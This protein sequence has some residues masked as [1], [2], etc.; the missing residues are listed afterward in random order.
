MNIR[1]KSGIFYYKHFLHI[2]LYLILNEMF[3]FSY[4]LSQEIGLKEILHKAISINP[5]IHYLENILKSK[6]GTIKQADVSPNPS[7]DINAGNKE[8]TI[9]FSQN[10]E[11]PGKR[12]ARK[13][14]ANE[15]KDIAKYQIMQTKIEIEKEISTIYYDVLWVKGNVNLYRENLDIT[16]KYMKSTKYQYDKGFNNK[17]DLLKSK[18]EL[19]RAQRLL[20]ESEQEYKSYISRLRAMLKIEPIKLIN[21]NDEFIKPL[22]QDSLNIDSLLDF[23]YINHPSIVIEQHRIKLAD[24]EID[25][26][27]LSTKPDFNLGLAGGM[28][29]GKFRAD[30]TISFPLTLWD[31]KEGSKIES[32]YEKKGYE[33]NLENIINNINIEI[34]QNFSLLQNLKEKIKLIEGNLISE[35]KETLEEAEKAYETGNFRLLDLIDAQRTYIEVKLEYFNTLHMLHHVEIDLITGIGKTI[36]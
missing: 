31:T 6:E 13:K 10:M 24:H 7:L 1:K 34:T 20:L 18:I 2:I 30:F 4:T 3:L 16:E 25:Q 35:A 29:E 23:A 5:R 21:L 15:E 26:I 17:I 28:E 11:F 8:Q 27:N 32:E 36:I 19:N 14:I 9:G 22:L 33:N 12:D